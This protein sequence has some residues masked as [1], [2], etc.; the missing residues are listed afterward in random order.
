MKAGGFQ[1]EAVIATIHLQNSR[2]LKV[3]I[4]RVH[5][6]QR[7]LDVRLFVNSGRYSGHTV[8]GVLLPPNV[9]P[10]L[11][12]AMTEGLQMLT[13]VSTGRNQW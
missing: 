5:G 7:H 1:E 11:Q 6:D 2:E 12:K 10:D 9:I 13:D 8:K 4:V 3:R